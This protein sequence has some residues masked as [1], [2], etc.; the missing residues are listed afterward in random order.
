M[1]LLKRIIKGTIT[2]SRPLLR[3][4][5]CLGTD[6]PRVL[7]YHRFAPPGTKIPHR[8]SADEFGW[9][10]D[11]IL[12]DFKVISLAEC[13]SYFAEKGCW[14]NKSVV[15]TIDDG[16]RDTFLWAY[17]ALLKRKLTA[18]F[19]VTTRFI[20]GDFWLWPDRIEYAIHHSR[21]TSVSIAHGD[22]IFTFPLQNEQQKAAAWKAFSDFCIKISDAERQQFIN[23]LE[24]TLEVSIP[25]SPP[26]EYAASPWNE[27]IEMHRNG[28]E[29]GSHTV[30]HPILS[31]I[32][33]SCLNREIASSKAYIE[34]QLASEIHS[35]CYPNSA[36]GDI[37]ADVVASVRDAGFTGAVFGSDFSVWDPY[38]IP[39]MGVSNDRNDFTWKIYGGETFFMT[40]RNR[41]PQNTQ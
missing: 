22:T 8:V 24:T 18:T 27:I 23:Q 41:K 6:R 37:N 1:S 11:M 38:R 20:D 9:Q 13:S 5:N 29:I 15:L 7:V 26:P 10:L 30:S 3:M 36:P 28:I 19:F 33:P 2:G 16:Y 14:P 12:R 35:F 34:Q 25:I 21:Q 40:L 31:K 17:P 39:R 32:E 4:L